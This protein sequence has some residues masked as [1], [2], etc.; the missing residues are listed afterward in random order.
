MRIKSLSAAL[1]IT[2]F[3]IFTLSVRAQTSSIIGT[4]DSAVTTIKQ[5]LPAIQE[6]KDLI[7]ENRQDRRQ[8]RRD[9]LRDNKE[10]FKER[11][12][13]IRDQRKSALVERIDERI[14]TMNK[15]HTGRFSAVLEK[16]KKIVSTISDGA[17][18]AKSKGV[19]T[20]AVDVAIASAKTAIDTAQ[21]AVT[22]QA[23]KIYSIEVTSEAALKINV[24]SV[25]SVFRKDLRDVHK[26]VVDAKKAVQKAHRELVLTRREQKGKVGEDQ[27]IKVAPEA[28]AQ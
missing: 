13:T 21:E 20:A 5:T 15:T 25:V 23:A 19:S 18:I 2:L 1:F 11:L 28:I 17:Q 3:S 27:S 14:S 8:D 4:R 7:L 22:M 26:M 6:Q 12:K 24:G 16:L 9:V 10:D